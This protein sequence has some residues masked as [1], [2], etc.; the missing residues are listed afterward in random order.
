M[1]RE[2]SFLRELIL[3]EEALP[4]HARHSNYRRWYRSPNVEDLWKH[5]FQDDRARVI[6]RIAKK[7]SQF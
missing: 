6:E 4:S 7:E 5:R 3:P 1:N 2:E